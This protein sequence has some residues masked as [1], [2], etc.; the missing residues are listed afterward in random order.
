MAICDGFCL[1]IYTNCFIFYLQDELRRGDV[2]K[3][4]Q[5]YMYETKSS[6]DKAREYIRNL[7]SNA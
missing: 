2:S 3:S 5:C 7:I 1:S 6:E 4:I